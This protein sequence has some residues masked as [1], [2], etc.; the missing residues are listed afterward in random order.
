MNSS[1]NLEEKLNTYSH[2]IGIILSFIGGYLIIN[3]AGT[4]NIGL[5]IYSL[6]LIV[7]FSASTLYHWVS[8]PTKKKR[9]RILDHIS[10]YYLIAG[11][12]T[13]VCLTLLKDSKGTLIL[14]IVW[15]IAFFGT[16]LKLFFTGKFEIF[17][18]VLYGVMGW[19]I[20]IDSN[21]LL[22]NSSSIA[23]FY[24]ALGGA[25]YTIGIIFYT[26]KKIPF[27]HFIWHLFVLGGAISHWFFIYNK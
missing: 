13:P 17:S 7:L 24:L 26:I 1:E 6:S 12:Y 14:C 23:L 18:L 22:S 25:F 3:K 4:L 19:V 5:I 8:N 11:T 27:N 10:I 16:I 9:L 2:A 20:V 15:I 21:Y